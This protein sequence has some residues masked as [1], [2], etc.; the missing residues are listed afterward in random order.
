MNKNVECFSVVISSHFR[1]SDTLLKKNDKNFRSNSTE[2][3][4]ST[5]FSK[6]NVQTI[7]YW[8]YA[9]TNDK[10]DTMVTK[11]ETKICYD[12]KRVAVEISSSLPL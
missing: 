8:K 1:I 5:H 7:I 11:N 3:E 9:K 12:V 6:H 2:Q 10:R 4:N